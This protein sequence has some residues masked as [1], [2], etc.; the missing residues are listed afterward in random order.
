MRQGVAHEP[1]EA[2]GRRPQ[3]ERLGHHQHEPQLSA[4][5]ALV[6]AEMGLG[7]GLDD[8]ILVLIPVTGALTIISAFAYFWGWLTHMAS[9]EPAPPP[10]PSRALQGKPV[11]GAPVPVKGAGQS[12]IGA[13]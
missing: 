1:G 3:P 6:L 13:S 8:L 5:A 2:T 9:Y 11:Q 7:L 12:R 4:R 10:R